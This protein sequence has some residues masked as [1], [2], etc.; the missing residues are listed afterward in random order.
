MLYQHLTVDILRAIARRYG[1]PTSGTRDDLIA[2]LRAF[3]RTQDSDHYDSAS[4]GSTHPSDDEDTAGEMTAPPPATTPAAIWQ[5]YN[6]AKIDQM[7]L[8]QGF[9]TTNLTTKAQK[10]AVLAQIPGLTPPDAITAYNALPKERPPKVD[11][12]LEKQA[13][14]EPNDQFLS[15]ARLHF[16]LVEHTNAQAQSVLNNAAQPQLRA[17]IEAQLLDGV[18]NIETLLKRLETKFTPNK[19]QY[20]DM[21]SSY[22]LP[23]GKTAQ[24][25]GTELRRLYILFLG[26]APD[27]V[28]DNEETINQT[29]TGR[30]LQVL[31]RDTAALL[32][33]DLLD[34]PDKTWEEI[35]AKADHLMPAAAD[36][37]R[38]PSRRQI[39]V[40]PTKHC[41]VHG[42]KGH[43]DAECKVQHGDAAEKQTPG[44]QHRNIKCLACYRYGHA[45]RDCPSNQKGNDTTGSP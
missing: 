6:D 1:L 2:R 16:K 24:E 21:F 43:T 26:Y 17:A 38:T 11:V 34:H 41:S 5:L 23:A 42:Y 44:K 37:P 39:T 3:E 36:K 35:L 29:L 20:F 4:Q 40:D 27:K 28:R 18:D 12:S 10:I 33:A 30:L 31:P 13:S 22:K 25:A 15:R 32:R 9:D 45:A 8:G 14:N 7:I 19:F